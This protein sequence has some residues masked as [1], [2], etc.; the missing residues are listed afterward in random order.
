MMFSPTILT[1]TAAA[2]MYCGRSSEDVQSCVNDRSDCGGERQP[3]TFQS[4][5]RG[6][7]TV[8]DLSVGWLARQE[9]WMSPSYYRTIAYS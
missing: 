3:L 8:G 1:W 2:R 5:A 4:S 7:R 9:Q 6:R